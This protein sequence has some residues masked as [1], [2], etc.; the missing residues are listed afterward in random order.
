MSR[1]EKI[2]IIWILIVQLIIVGIYGIITTVSYAQKEKQQNEAIEEIHVL[3]LQST[4]DMLEIK[5]QLQTVSKNELELETLKAEVAQLRFT[6]ENIKS[7][8]F[9]LEMQALEK[10]KD[11]EEWF[12]EYKRIT[13]TYRDFIDPP[14]TI[15]DV[16]AQD[17]IDLMCR[18]VQTEVG[19]G[20]FECKVHV[21]DVVWNRM[22]DSAW[23]D[24]ITQIITSPNQFAY[25]KTS[26][27]EST[28]LAVEYSFLFPDTTQGALS[29]H[30]LPM[31]ETFGGYKFIFEDEIGHKFYG[32]KGGLEE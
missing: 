12:I 19:G 11:K 7:F 10:I 31:R 8:E 30:S 25:G 23:P 9:D 4:K 22:D 17:E 14:E 13:D 27:T 2:R 26:Y 6:E 32:K 24:T 29:F 20:D 3:Q 15:Y 5:E 16:Y 18:M 28:K 21:A 1:E